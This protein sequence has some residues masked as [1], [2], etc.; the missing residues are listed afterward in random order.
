M[1]DNFARHMSA[2]LEFECYNPDN[3]IGYLEHKLQQ[4]VDI[5]TIMPERSGAKLRAAAR[6]AVWAM[7]VA[8]KTSEPLPKGVQQSDDGRE[9]W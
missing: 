5:L 7:F 2:Q 1:I 4:D 3:S 8:E 9:N 6:V